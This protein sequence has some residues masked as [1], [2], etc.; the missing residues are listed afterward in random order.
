MEAFFIL[1]A[2]LVMRTLAYANMHTLYTKTNTF[3]IC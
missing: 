3:T 1:I 2:L